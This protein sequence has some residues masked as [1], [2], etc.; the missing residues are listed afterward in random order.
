MCTQPL[1]QIVACK[2]NFYRYPLEIHSCSL[3]IGLW[4]YSVEEV[5]LTASKNP[6]GLEE[7]VENPQFYLSKANA[8][9]ILPYR[10]FI[11]NVTFS[12]INYTFI[13]ENSVSAVFAINYLPGIGKIH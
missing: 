2:P 1:K 5:N 9:N 13:L 12:G 8:T 10:R 6:I 11:S 4:L 7:L 3:E